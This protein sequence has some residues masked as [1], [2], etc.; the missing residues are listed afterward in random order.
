MFNFKR[1]N[2]ESLPQN[3]ESIIEE[4]SKIKKEN[5]EIK[6]ELREI[7]E[8]QQY[9]LQN[10]EIERFNPFHEGGGDQS[11]SVALLDKNGSGVVITGLYT[12]EGSRVYGKPVEKGSSNY[13]LSSEE[14][15]VINKALKDN[16]RKKD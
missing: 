2:K 3:I 5:E 14:V 1:K 6:K 4:V 16:S 8:K 11:F 9:F 13:S 10:I 7:R 15:K 12:K